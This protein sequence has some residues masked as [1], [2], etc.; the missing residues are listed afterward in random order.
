V[1]S[2]GDLLDLTHIVVVK[3][4]DT[5]ETLK[6][7]LGFSPLVHP[8]DGTRFGQAGFHPYWDWLVDLGE[9]HEMIISI[10]NSGFAVIV[11]IERGSG[12]VSDMCGRFGD[13]LLQPPG[14]GLI[15]PKRGWEG[16]PTGCSSAGAV[17]CL[18]AINMHPI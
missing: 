11:L 10:G 1:A 3:G 17:T 12:A 9:W 13:S 5:E 16:A 14:I 2:E 7:E 18:N 4:C 6:A 8:I 15:W